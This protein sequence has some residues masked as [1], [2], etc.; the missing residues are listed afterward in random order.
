M[1]CLNTKAKKNSKA[2]QHRCTIASSRGFTF[3]KKPGTEVK[4]LVFLSSYHIGPKLNTIFSLR[5]CPNIALLSG[6]CITIFLK[7]KMS[8]KALSG[9]KA[10]SL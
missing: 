6:L 7:Y 4:Q 9:K 10:S 2:K 1:E 5:K 3:V 8:R